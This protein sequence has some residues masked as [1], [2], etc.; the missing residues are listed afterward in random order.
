[1]NLKSMTIRVSSII[2]VCANEAVYIIPSRKLH[3]NPIIIIFIKFYVS[4]L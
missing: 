1:M 3:T 2:R 4:V